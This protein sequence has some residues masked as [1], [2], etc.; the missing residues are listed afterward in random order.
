MNTRN[1]KESFGGIALI[2]AAVIALIWA[3]S[4][5]AA[6]YESMI[7]LEW[8]KGVAIFLFFMSIGI[9]LRHEIQ[10]G[11]LRSA[12][13]AIVPIFAAMGGMMVPVLIYSAF[14]FHQPTEA[15]WGIAMSTDVAFALAVFAI[16][17]S[18][19]PR[20]IRTFVLTVAVVDDSLTILMIAI[21]YA[22]SFHVLS[23]VSLSGVVIG[24]FLPK[25]QK[26][27]PK[28]QPVVSFGALPIFALFS[29]GVD[30]S[31]LNLKDFSTSAI[32]IGILTAMIIGKP[33]GVLGTTYL[34]TKSGLGKLS[35]DIKWADL[36]P[37]GFLFSMCFTVALLMS[38]LSFGERETEHSTANL[39]V[40]IGSTIAAILATVAISLRRSAHA[41][42]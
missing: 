5:A 19:L 23:L 7:Q 2:S 3:N 25:G 36:I 11:S 13:N 1:L 21:F 42:K 10:H 24:I 31:T 39:S 16:A 9:E 32:T 26:L 8:I 27:L 18:F 4:P 29:A 41:K 37:A 6:L 40:F 14:N 30:L 12:R 17:G 33:L 35:S 34:V 38:E 20:A 22:S 28:L 15:G